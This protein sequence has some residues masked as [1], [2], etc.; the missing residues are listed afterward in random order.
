MKGKK[1]AVK[2]FQSALDLDIKSKSYDFAP[3]DQVFTYQ[4]QLGKDTFLFFR[5]R[6]MMF[7]YIL[8]KDSQ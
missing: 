4:F 2:F 6:K 7:C 5:E 8:A 1:E 3:F